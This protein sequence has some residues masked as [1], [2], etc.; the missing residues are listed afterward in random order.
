VNDDHALHFNRPVTA[1]VSSWSV[2]GSVYG[3]RRLG[4]RGMRSSFDDRDSLSRRSP[5]GIHPSPTQSEVR[6]ILTTSRLVLVV[7]ARLD[8]PRG[9]GDRPAQCV[10]APGNLRVGHECGLLRSHL[11][12]ERRSRR[13]GSD[14]WH[15]GRLRLD[16][17]LSHDPWVLAVI[18]TSG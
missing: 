7:P 18:V 10:D 4:C 5:N 13:S 2:N 9:L 12:G 1:V 6:V 3:H 14:G 17:D 11:A 8:P 16:I 15:S